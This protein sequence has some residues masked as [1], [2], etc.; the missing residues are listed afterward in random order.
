[1][2][3]VLETADRLFTGELD[4]A[5]HHPFAS[6]DLAEMAD[7]TV[8]VASFAN[9]SAIGTDDGL[10][11]VDT[12]SQ[13][14]AGTVLDSCAG[15]APIGSTP[16]STPTATSTTS[17]ASRSSRTSDGTAGRRRVVAHEAL[18]A[19]F[20]RYILTAGYNGVINQRQFQL[21]R[22]CAGRAEY[23]Y[24]DV[25]YADG[26]TSTSVASRSSCTTPRRDRRPH[27]DVDARARRCSAAATCSSGRRPNAGNPQKVQRYPVEWAAALREMAA[28]ERRAAA[29]RATACRSS[30]ADRIRRRCSTTAPSCSRPRRRRR[31]S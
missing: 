30:G 16:R 31:S 26:S 25:T 17:S 8:F 20:D 13:F 15:G 7:D 4:P 12:G 1:M 2:P 24:P 21:A 28:L 27:L 14:F 23:R 6:G 19:R 29:A 10:V 5:D 22:A 11:L 18:P 9:V 3:D